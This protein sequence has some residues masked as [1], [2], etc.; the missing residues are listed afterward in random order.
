[1]SNSQTAGHM[2][3][4]NGYEFYMLGLE[5][6]LYTKVGGNYKLE[7]AQAGG[8]RALGKTI[9]TQEARVTLPKSEEGKAKPAG[10]GRSFYSSPE[11]GD[12]G[13]LTLQWPY[14][15][16]ARAHSEEQKPTLQQLSVSVR[17]G[18]CKIQAETEQVQL[19]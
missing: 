9:R 7:H 10:A 13:G 11:A 4:L 1:M 15:A 14:S 19:L 17:L 2:P 8:D 12:N 6:R 18:N 3:R 5:E 16:V